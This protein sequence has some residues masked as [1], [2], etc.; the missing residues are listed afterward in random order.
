MTT[1]RGGNRA[2][3]STSA[4]TISISGSAFGWR[5]RRTAVTSPLSD[6]VDQAAARRNGRAAAARDPG[7]GQGGGQCVLGTPSRAVP[8]HDEIGGHRGERATVAPMI[9]SNAGPPRCR[10]PSRACNGGTP[11]RRWAWRTMLT[12]PACP[13]PVSTTKPRP[14]TCTTRAWSSTTSGSCRQSRPGHAW[15]AGGMPRSNSVVRSTSPVIS[16]QPSTSSEGSPALDHGEALT[17][18][19]PLAQRRQFLGLATGYGQPAAGPDRAGAPPSATTGPRACL[20]DRPARLRGRN[21][22][23]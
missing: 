21:G 23:G 2:A 9:G 17:L 14:R 6:L 12:A 15:C 3:A 18:Q 4:P 5:V 7:V 19:R 16:T 20:P 13:Q 1:H 8:R 10:P 11:V 22:R